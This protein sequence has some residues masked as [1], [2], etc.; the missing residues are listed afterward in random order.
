MILARW[1][2][3]MTFSAFSPSSSSPFSDPPIAK[4]PSGIAP[5]GAISASHECH[6]LDEEDVRR[7]C[8]PLHVEVF[9]QHLLVRD[10]PP[11]DPWTPPSISFT[12]RHG[13][14]GVS[15]NISVTVIGNP[16]ARIMYMV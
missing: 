12:R 13:I 10:E 15:S 9:T 14:T 16:L 5:L 8:L 1:W 3:G 6:N 7:E 2:L 4:Y 11:I